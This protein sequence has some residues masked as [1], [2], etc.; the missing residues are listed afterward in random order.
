[1]W[2]KWHG[3][4]LKLSEAKRKT[5]SYSNSATALLIFAAG[6]AWLWPQPERGKLWT[7]WCQALTVSLM[8]RAVASK[9]LPKTKLRHVETKAGVRQSQNCFKHILECVWTVSEPFDCLEQWIVLSCANQKVL[10][11]RILKT[12]WSSL[13]ASLNHCATCPFLC[14][15]H[16]VLPYYRMPHQSSAC[17][18]FS[19]LLLVPTYFFQNKHVQHRYMYCVTYAYVGIYVCTRTHT[20][21]L[22]YNIYII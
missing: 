11:S 5:A 1:M 18:R 17:R 19:Y 6:F 21:C 2:I 14:C 7:R 9:R 15:P 10:S 3:E 4:R 22:Q 16:T 12:L 8:S 13:M 20:A